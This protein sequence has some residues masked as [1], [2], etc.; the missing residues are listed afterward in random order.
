MS[1]VALAA[2]SL[3]VLA[4]LLIDSAAISFVRE[5]YRDPLIRLL[6]SITD[7][8]ASEWY[9]VPAGLAVVTLALADWSSRGARARSRL[10]YV[11]GVSAYLFAAVAL[12]GILVNVAKLLVGRARPI[13]FDELGPWAFRPFQFEYSFLSYPSGHSTTVGAAVLVA[14][15]LLPR[16]RWLA[17]ALGAVVAFS[18]VAALAHY[19]GDVIA[20]FAFGWLFALWLARWLAARGLVFRTL[21]GRVLPVPRH[22]LAWRRRARGR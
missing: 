6:A 13:L 8:G 1:V 16:L 10:T 14:M 21:P 17:L 22:Q 15:L 11:F 4:G 19:P 7:L 5:H 3:S 9:L 12:S 20:G 2:L 18:R